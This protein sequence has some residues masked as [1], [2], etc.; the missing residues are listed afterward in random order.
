MQKIKSRFG[1]AQKEVEIGWITMLATEAPLVLDSGEVIDN[2][3]CA[4]FTYGT[5]NQDKSNA[6]LI[7]HGLSGDQ[8]VAGIHPVTGRQ[9]WWDRY[10]GPH[11]IIDTQT[12]FVICINVLGG[13]MGTFGPKTIDPSTGEPYGLRFPMITIADMV[14]VQAMLVSKLGIDQL[15]A[16]IGGSMGGMQVLEWMAQF[17]ERVFAAIPIATSTRHTA[18][19]IAFHEIGRY[20]IIADDNFCNGRYLA[21]KKFPGEGLAIARMTAHITYFSDSQLDRRF[22]RHLQKGEKFS[23]RFEQEFQIESYLHHLGKSFVEVFDPNSYL[24]ISRAMD[25]FDL[26]RPH[27]GNLASAFQSYPSPVCVISFA[28]D[29][30]YPSIESVKIVHALNSIGAQVTYIDIPTDQGHDAF[31]MDVE[32]FQQVLTSFLENMKKKRGIS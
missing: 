10:V 9:G 11:K 12:Y 1:I 16:V 17:K 23:Y 28:S 30:L 27:Q 4:Y 29:W 32:I 5:L 20:S 25:Y 26:S 22:G 31:L 14:R 6:I 7:C 21:E 3:P 2:F 8:Y 15:F 19:N 13:C 24:Y 18:Q